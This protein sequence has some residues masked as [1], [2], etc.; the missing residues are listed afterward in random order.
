MAILTIFRPDFTDEEWEAFRAAYDRSYDT[1]ETFHIVLDIQR[2]NPSSCSHLWSFIQYLAGMRE[3]TE[4]QVL[5]IYIVSNHNRL[6]TSTIENMLH[7]Y[8][9]TIDI[10]FVQSVDQAAQDIQNKAPAAAPQGVP[11]VL[12]R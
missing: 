2:I 9:N 7:W 11:V 8:G 1:M 3:K 10:F 4:R 6:V 5:G 12:Q